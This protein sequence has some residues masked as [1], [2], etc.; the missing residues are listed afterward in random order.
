MQLL[1]KGSNAVFRRCFV[2]L[3]FFQQCCHQRNLIDLALQPLS[4][5]RAGVVEGD[6]HIQIQITA[7]RQNHRLP[8]YLPQQKSI[9]QLHRDT[10]KEKFLKLS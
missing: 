5:K 6:H 8:R 3:V 7:H 10:S 4:Q 9:L 1:H 2:H